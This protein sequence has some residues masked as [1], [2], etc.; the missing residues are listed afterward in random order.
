MTREELNTSIDENVTDRTIENPSSAPLIGT[1]IKKVADYIDDRISALPVGVATAGIVESE[2]TGANTAEPLIYDYNTCIGNSKY[3]LL[4]GNPSIGKMI[5][6]AVN[7]GGGVINVV[8]NTTPSARISTTSNNSFSGTVQ[9]RNLK[10]FRFI[11]IGDGYWQLEFVDSEANRPLYSYSSTTA[12]LSNADLNATYPFATN[13]VGSMVFAP[14]ISGGG[15]V[16][17]RTSSASWAE[18]DLNIT[19]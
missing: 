12:A 18:S 11:H 6:V 10:V 16:Y 15:K 13:I 2:S 8:A 19:A 17:F 9:L 14:L 3:F 1:E 5:Y 7:A 4:P